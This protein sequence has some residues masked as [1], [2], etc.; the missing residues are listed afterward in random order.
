MC[1]RQGDTGN[2]PLLR[3]DGQTQLSHPHLVEVIIWRKQSRPSRAQSLHQSAAEWVF[4]K[5]KLYK[6]ILLSV[7][8][9]FTVTDMN[10][11]RGLGLGNI[12][13]FVSKHTQ[14]RVIVLPASTS[15]Y[16]ENT[17]LSV[18][19]PFLYYIFN[20]TAPHLPPQQG[21][22]KKNKKK[23][24]FISLRQRPF[25]TRSQR[26]TSVSPGTFIS[27]EKWLQEGFVTNSECNRPLLVFFDHIL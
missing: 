21:I 18:P 19:L 23:P 6:Q 27:T 8:Q 12:S 5:S 22:F 7:D 10:V 26:P 20:Q 17:I 25:V 13:P 9:H 2:S 1:V 4:L 14:F 3:T 15:V 16:T 11:Q 24:L